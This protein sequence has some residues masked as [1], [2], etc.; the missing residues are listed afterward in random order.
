[1]EW[2]KCRTR[3]DRAG[4]RWAHNAD[5]FVLTTTS[6]VKERQDKEAVDIDKEMENLLKKQ[7]YLEISNKNATQHIEQIFNHQGS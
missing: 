7:Q 1:M 4:R 2:E 3:Y 6:D 5:R